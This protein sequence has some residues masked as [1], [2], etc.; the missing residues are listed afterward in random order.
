[1]DRYILYDSC[2]QIEGSKIR[3]W[4]NMHRLD[5]ITNSGDVGPILLPNLTPL[6]SVVC[7]AQTLESLARCQTWHSW[8]RLR[9]EPKRL[10]V[11]QDIRPSTNGLGYVLNPNTCGSGEIPDLTLF[12]LGYT[13]SINARESEEMPD[14]ML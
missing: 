9:V 12:G 8:T 5:K 7:W 6:S 14:P 1:M 3:W 10:W 11:W 4:P 2:P 13:R